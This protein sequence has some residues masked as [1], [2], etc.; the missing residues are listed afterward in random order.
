MMSLTG[1]HLHRHLLL[2]GLHAFVTL[3]A[4]GLASGQVALQ[5]VDVTGSSGIHFEHTD[6]SSGKHY[7]VES[8]SAGVAL[9]DYDLDGDL[10]IYFVNG[11]PLEGTEFDVP[12]TNALYRNDGGWRFT[13]VTQLAGVG[14]DGY[15]LGATAGDFNN[16]GYPDLYVSNLGSNVL[17]RN[18]G[19]GTFIDATEEAGVTDDERFGAGVAF[20]DMDNDGDLDLYVANYL[21]FSYELHKPHVHRGIPAYPSPL[22]Y[23]PERDTLFRNEGNGT[24]TDVTESAGIAAHAAPG[25]GVV[26]AD[27]DNDGDTDVF[28]AND[29]HANF[30]FNNDGQGNFTDV[31]LLAGT[32]F[33][34]SG[35]A[36]ASMGVDA[37]DFDNDGQIDFHVTSFAGEFATLYHNLGGGLL[38]DATQATGAGAGTLPHVTWGNGFAD[39]DNDGDRD[40]FVACGHLDDLY[41]QRGNDRSTA[42]AVPNVLLQNLGPDD[43]FVDVSSQA[44]DGL[45][46]SHSSRGCAL[47]DLDNDGDLDAVVMNIREKPT[48]LRNESPARHHS[49]KLRLVATRSNRQAVGARVSVVAGDLVQVDEVRSGRGY[50]SDFGNILHFGLGKQPG[51][52]RIEVRWPGGETEVFRGLRPQPAAITLTEGGER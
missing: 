46:A 26:C 8:F 51:V 36:Q 5:L 48:L 37:G 33:D 21:V 6:G 1:F 19:D 28:V 7:I 16:D 17:Y 18:Q 12:P 15:G 2:I 20:F 4:P 45:A 32:A 31:A 52:D 39:F 40:I 10:D 11:A 49:I 50:Q 44:G 22:G 41:G 30:L 9:L 38:E 23:M 35:R 13:D 27:Y 3:S 25:M 47:G 43:G 29:M 14:D 42:F 34:F 24:F